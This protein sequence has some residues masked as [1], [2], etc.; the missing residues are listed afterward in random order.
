MDTLFSSVLLI[1]PPGRLRDGIRALLRAIP[2]L[3]AITTVD[4][5]HAARA[6]L[7]G[8]LP[9]LVLLDAGFSDTEGLG[10]LQ[11][12]LRRER[13]EVGLIVL[14]ENARQMAQARHAQAD[15]VLLKGFSVSAL[16]EALQS[17]L[18][19]GYTLALPAATRDGKK[20]KALA[21]SRADRSSNMMAWSSN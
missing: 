15:W 20:E 1:S 11:M 21:A 9:G 13:P 4:E 5:P 6:Y 7:Q 3:G 8:N 18:P 2:Q 17:L 16:Q 10:K 19:F 14:A 12:F